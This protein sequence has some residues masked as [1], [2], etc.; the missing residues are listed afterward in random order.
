MKKKNIVVTGGCGFIG[1]N[2]IKYLISKTKF[3]IISIDDHSSGSINNQIKHSRIKYFKA[4]T[5]NILNTLHK[6]RSAINSIFHF[7]EFSRIHQSF[8]D[9]ERCF[10]SNVSG[11]A[12]VFSFCLKNK[13]KIIYSATSA[14]LGNSGK[15]KSLS[16]YA[17]TKST[18]LQLLQHMRKLFGLSYECLY[19]YNVYGPGQIKEGPMSTIIGIFESQLEKNKFL[20]VTKPGTQSRKFTHIDDTVKGCFFAWKKNACRHYSLSN[21]KSYSILSV[22]KMFS[23]KIKFIPK[24]YGERKKSTNPSKIRNTKIY[25]YPCKMELKFYIKE[26]KKKLV[27]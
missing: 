6:Y 9:T 21:N 13:I 23:D 14:S 1:S 17:L 3:N 2:L 8:I 22:A 10:R 26:F 5:L 12:D 19:F 16:P 27:I 7:G 24:R 20:T 4:S 15:D 11:T 25:A 18:N